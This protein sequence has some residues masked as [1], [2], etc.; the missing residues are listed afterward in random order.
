MGSKE[1]VIFNVLRYTL[2]D[3]PGIR[4]TVFLKGCPLN[5][6]WC[7]NP[8]SQS[9]VPE[10][11]HR[12]LTCIKCQSCMAICPQKAINVT[13]DGIQVDRQ[14]CDICLKC[15]DV[16]PTNTMQVMG[17]CMS[18]EE[19]YRIIRKDIQYYENSGG[20]IT[21]SGGEPLSQADF[22][23]ALFAKCKEAG[24]H[25]CLDTSGYGKAS[26]LERVLVY[27][28]LVYFDIKSLNE[29]RHLEYV[30]QGIHLIQSNLALINSKDVELVIRIP[31]IPDFNDSETEIEKIASLV[32][33]LHSGVKVHLLPFHRYGQSKYA[34]LDRVFT[35]YDQ[36]R[37][38]EAHLQALR[39]VFTIKGLVCA[40]RD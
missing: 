37:P 21:V 13:A 15:V 3:G 2:D 17:K 29:E 7:A 9:F 12:D 5:C 36:E 30:G 14:R 24:I 31:I 38:S 27:T 6:A 19:T 35:M 8:E 26:D 25:T 32:H 10:L 40:I 11:L 33:N 39:R 23:E 22:V 1:A 34:I 4:S 18:L 20:G 28:D 16:C